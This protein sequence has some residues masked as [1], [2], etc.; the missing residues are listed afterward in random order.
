MFDLNDSRARLFNRETRSYNIALIVLS[1]ISGDYFIPRVFNFT[2]IYFELEFA[3]K[4]KP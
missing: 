2:V 1:L 4:R 3:R